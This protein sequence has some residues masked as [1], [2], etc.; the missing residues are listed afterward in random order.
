MATINQIL[1]L[2][3]N[4][5]WQSTVKFVIEEAGLGFVLTFE[6]PDEARRFVDH[7]S[8]RIGVFVIGDGISSS[9]CRTRE[10]VKELCANGKGVLVLSSF[11]EGEFPN[12]PFIKKGEF[13]N[14]N[15]FLAHVYSMLSL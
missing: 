10:W 1:Y 14:G 5:H 2:E 13:G 12:V 4:P 11:D 6:Y 15:K 9:S 8:S 7:Q 3:A